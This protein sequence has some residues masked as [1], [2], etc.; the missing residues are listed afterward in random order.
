M[1]LK[2]GISAKWHQKQTDFSR[3]LDLLVEWICINSFGFTFSYIVYAIGCFPCLC[4]CTSVYIVN[5][6]LI[7]G[8]CV[9]INFIESEWSILIHYWSIQLQYFFWLSLDFHMPSVSYRVCCVIF[10][11]LSPF[12]HR[13]FFCHG[14]LF[15]LDFHTRIY[16]ETVSSFVQ[17]VCMLHS[18][19]VFSRKKNNIN[20][21]PNS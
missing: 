16:T 4:A 17:C 13:F 3:W 12:F 1:I 10:F 6:S 11:P 19:K 7:F 5:V 15:T 21:K 20:F 2:N 8:V 18:D 9:W 14:P